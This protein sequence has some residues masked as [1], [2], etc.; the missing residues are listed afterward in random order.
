[1][2][3]RLRD[4][5][6][7]AAW[8]TTE[9][10]KRGWKAEEV[11]RRLR[12]MGYAA[13]DTTYRTWEAA[14]GRKPAPDTIRALERLFESAA[15]GEDA[16]GSGDLAAALQ[17]LADEIRAAREERA[18]LRRELVAARDARVAWERAVLQVLQAAAAGQVPAELLD[19]LA[20]QTPEPV[21]RAR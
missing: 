7:F 9:R 21:G 1:M 20:P 14:S 8:L 10:G 11:A 18:E 19:A 3:Y 6:P 4:K 15:P 12:D 13:E 5:P 16:T 17:S 2:T